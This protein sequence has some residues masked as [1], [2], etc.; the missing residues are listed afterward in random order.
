M[1]DEGARQDTHDADLLS[2][3]LSAF[4]NPRRYRQ[5]VP[6]PIW[7]AWEFGEIDREEFWARL[8]R[9]WGIAR[10]SELVKRRAA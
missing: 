7:R 4:P 1:N 10:V 6:G 9:L 5:R 8:V 2:L 3:R